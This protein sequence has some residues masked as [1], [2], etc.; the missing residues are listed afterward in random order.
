MSKAITVTTEEVKK[1]A[2]LANLS[3]PSNQETQFAQQ[4]SDTL[5]VVDELNEIDTSKL[6]A[7][8]QVNGLSNIT[9]EDIVKPEYG[10]TQTEALSQAKNTYNGYFVVNRLIDSN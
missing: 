7:T 1:I 9:R 4:F 8:Y 6:S 3:L 10:L 5:K 2:K